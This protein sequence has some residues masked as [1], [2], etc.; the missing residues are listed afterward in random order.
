MQKDQ[1][2]RM[3]DHDAR[4]AFEDAKR[5]ALTYGGQV[6]PIHI[7]AATL[8]RQSVAPPGLASTGARAFEAALDTASSIVKSHLSSHYPGK[9]DSLVVTRGAQSL[10]ARAAEIAGSE[11][12]ALATPLTLLKA[13]L[14]DLQIREE[15]G[16]PEADAA[17]SV[18]KT[19]LAAPGSSIAGPEAPR[20]S[21]DVPSVRR[22]SPGNPKDTHTPGA[23][24]SF[25]EDLALRFRESHPFTGRD[26]EVLAVLETL[27]R[28]L[29]NNPLLI[30]KP[31]VGK[32]AL[33]GAVAT[34]LAEG[35][36]PPRLKG[37]RILEVS[38]I[39][40]LADAKYSGEIEERLK[41]LLEEI[42]L[43][44]DI[45]LFF[46]E[47]H[48]LL[49][50]GGTP[51]TGDVA[52][53]LKSALSRGDFTCIG[54]TTQAEYYRYMA[55][56]EALARR[57]STI[58]VEEP[59]ADATRLIL[60]GASSSFESYHSVRIDAEAIRT[61]IEDARRYLPSRSF[62][63]KAFDLMDKAAAKAA[64]AGKSHLDRCE[65]T[66]AL[67]EMTGLPLEVMEDDP[68]GRLERLELYLNQAVPG[69]PGAARDVAR[70]VRIAK[71]G[72]EARSE[73]PDGVFLFVGGEGSG[74]R[75]MTFALAE[76]LYGSARK[77]TEFDM[78]QFT[79]PWSLSRLV[80]AEPGYAGYNERSG[81]LGKAA[82]DN[83]HSVF[84]FRNID[85]AHPAIQT[86]LAEALDRGTF[87]E[88][89]GTLVSISNTTVVL[90]L[91]H[92]SESTRASRV[93][94][95]RESRT[96]QLR[97]DA[98]DWSRF[99]LIDSIGAVID[100]VIEFQPLDQVATEKV[101][102]SRLEGLRRQIE[103][104]Q[105]VKVEMSSRLVGFLIDK[106][107]AEG[108]GLAQLDHLIQE[109]IVAPF[110][111]LHMDDSGLQEADQMDLHAGHAGNSGIEGE[112]SKG[113]EPGNKGQAGVMAPQTGFIISAEGGAVTI[114]RIEPGAKP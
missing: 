31:G 58:T 28:K 14:E 98:E 8:A 3:L 59:S 49:G 45:I 48:A 54:A 84:L 62:P 108:H 102:A 92:S 71:L 32:T 21:D 40:L 89:T 12:A 7:L 55:R 103:S 24:N 20:P 60:E 6:S 65:I 114:E 87:T 91:S 90:C 99:G 74:K 111:L 57:F 96:A 26:R 105:P 27:C 81:L 51:G 44:G 56:D 70:V 113:A 79:E 95:F 82:E 78:S 19:S 66:E 4:E 34:R 97:R 76:F 30:G 53:L 88:S 72:L 36:V 50:A 75:E 69:Q 35:Q 13:A 67:S 73:R 109:T 2:L 33:A 83:P 5:L 106:L 93:G 22:I 61:I 17:F 47:I 86:F 107:A 110:S 1:L 94:F 80:G 100:E 43:A 39:K 9:T 15:L 16:Q 104:A 23:L 38:R 18:I 37:K 52:T 85:L 64:L 63:D 11:G 41:T 112:S 46:D 42:Q 10:L 68:C 25:C 29:K 77:V 101:V